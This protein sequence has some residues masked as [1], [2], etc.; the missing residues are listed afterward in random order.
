MMTRR[1]FFA[2]TACLGA[3]VAL[4]A[5]PQEKSNPAAS[6]RRKPLKLGVCT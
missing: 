3:S 6:A 2:S 5:E 4:G 1:S